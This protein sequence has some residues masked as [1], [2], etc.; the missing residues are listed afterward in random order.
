MSES[1]EAAPV[2]ETKEPVVAG[3]KGN[4]EVK[5][6]GTKFVEFKSAEEQAR[7]NRMYGHMKQ[8]E[9]VTASL[10]EQNRILLEKFEKIENET[11]QKTWNELKAEKVKA[12]E[13]G[14][15]VRSVDID[16]QMARLREK[17]EEKEKPRP[18]PQASV[19]SPEQE[20]DI[21]TWSS[22]TTSEGNWK[23]PWS[24][25]SHPLHMKFANLAAGVMNDPAYSSKGVK[26]VL[27]EANR[28]M[29]SQQ[30]SAVRPSAGVLGQNQDIRQTVKKV[31][32]LTADQKFVA[33][34]MYPNLS[35]DA[36]IAKYA[37]AV[38]KAPKRA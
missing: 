30:Q 15:H 25:P 14:E 3:E 11:R 33:L 2:A 28:L 6:D 36:A 20:E 7:W 8:S 5:P 13:L 38:S 32:D 23:R 19:F 27:E 18:A 12:L 10:I 17:P 34:R 22:E 24:Q 16:E 29:T 35:E 1:T 21:R 26:A 9:R 31:S 4:G 37:G